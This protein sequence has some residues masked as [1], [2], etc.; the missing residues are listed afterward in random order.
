MGAPDPGKIDMSGRDNLRL[1]ITLRWLA[2]TGQ[3]VTVLAVQ[4]GMDVALPLPPMF[5]IILSLVVLN[6]ASIWR[7][8]R[9]TPISN[10]ELFAALMLDVAALSGLLYF[11]GGATNPFVALYLLQVVLGAVLLDTWSSWAM[12][13]VTTA[14]FALLVEVHE[15]LRLPPQLAV[16]AFGLY[17]S[18]ALAAFVID[19]ILL[20][21]FV[22]RFSK[23]LRA[24]D[25]RLAAMRQHAAEEDH[26]VRMGLLASGA[27]HE[28]GTPLASLAV[29][30]NDWRT[31]PGVG[32]DPERREELADAAAALARCK[33]IVTGI[34]LSA[35]DARGE[36]TAVTSI[37]TWLAGLAGEWRQQHPEPAL[38]YLDRFSPDMAIVS[39]TA[40]KQVIWNVL[41]NAADASEDRIELTATRLDSRLELVVRDHGP[42][43]APEMLAQFGRPY[44]STKGRQGGGLGLFLVVNVMRKLGGEVSARNLAD[45][46]EV[47]LTLPLE[48]LAIAEER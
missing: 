37:K 24:R 46:A 34:L 32:D 44:R 2:V 42:G 47:T 43:F 31:T 6:A 23:N 7:L 3:M 33:S 21:A 12:V 9:A 29:I 14:C 11:S 38:H 8:E 41:D 1:L 35:G 25:A 10:I 5:A 19:A 27:A 17:I 20:V 18:G 48:A 45:G 22:A 36:Q 13:V 28:L 30:L 26:I 4:I 40:L 39:D 16:G 15:P